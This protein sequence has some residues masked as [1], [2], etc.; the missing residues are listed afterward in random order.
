MLWNCYK[1]NDT[2]L[3]LKYLC[4]CVPFISVVELRRFDWICV[5]NYLILNLFNTQFNSKCFYHTSNSS[6]YQ[7]LQGESCVPGSIGSLH[8]A[9]CRLE[10]MSS[11]HF[12]ELI[13]E[14]FYFKIYIYKAKNELENKYTSNLIICNSDCVLNNTCVFIKFID[15]RKIIHS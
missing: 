13:S 10:K 4:N 12:I 11:Q 7:G 2:Q 14:R 8:R 3:L 1:M 6:Y 9:F 15:I 5:I